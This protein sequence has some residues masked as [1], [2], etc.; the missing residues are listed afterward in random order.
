M[1]IHHS[2]KIQSSDLR[3]GRH[4]SWVLPGSYLGN[5]FCQ[6][7]QNP[8]ERQNIEVSRLSKFV[9]SDTLI[10]DQGVLSEAD[11]GRSLARTVAL[12]VTLSALLAPPCFVAG[13]RD[14]LTPSQMQDLFSDIVVLCISLGFFWEI[15][16]WNLYFFFLF[17]GPLIRGRSWVKQTP[18]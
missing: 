6:W 8:G 1:I 4:I 14:T 9:C 15:Q 18:W 11:S 16:I 10:S 3:K 5:Q 12:A 7:Q 17:V 2:P 13:L